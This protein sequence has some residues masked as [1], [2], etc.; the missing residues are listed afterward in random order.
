M[1][2]C[3]QCDGIGQY[4]E[5]RNRKEFEDLLD[6]YDHVGTLDPI[7]CRERALKKV[8]YSLIVCPSCKGTGEE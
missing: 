4:K 6:K 3:F 2:K 1:A 8:G 5:P 7:T